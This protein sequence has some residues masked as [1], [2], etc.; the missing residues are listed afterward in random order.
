MDESNAN[1]TP[2]SF[3][4]F[5]AT[6]DLFA[7]KIVPSLYLL[8]TTGKLPNEFAVLGF[9]RQAL[10]TELFQDHVFVHLKNAAP[11][12]TKR[13]A[14]EFL[15]LFTYQQGEFADEASF[16]R[17]REA[18]EARDHALGFP[19]L[20]SFYLA[21]PP[22]LV[23]ILVPHLAM[24]APQGEARQILIEKP[25]G[26]DETSAREL[27]A[28][29][30]D[31]FDEREIFRID[32]YLAKPALDTLLYSR[33]KHERYNQLL[34]EEPIQ[35][36]TITLLETLGVEKRGAFYD[37][38]GALKDV[39]QNHL[40]EMLALALMPIPRLEPASVCQ[41]RAQFL[42]SLPRLST[43]EVEEQTIRAQ[44]EGYEHIAGVREGS[45]TETYFRVQFALKSAPY[46]DVAVVLESGK[47]MRALKKD[48]VISFDCN[49]TDSLH[50]ELEPVPRIYLK[51]GDLITTLEEFK[52]PM[53]SIQYANEYATLFASAWRGDTTHFPTAREVER[54]W[55]F[56][57]PIVLAW[58][59][60]AP[61]LLTYPQG[62]VLPWSS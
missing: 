62:A 12:V 14:E 29:L 30:H 9:G 35:A 31:F 59:E 46:R 26:H 56:I 54:L 1:E 23:R 44:Y 60:G 33:T 43:K 28:F 51:K 20:K 32:H 3:V 47:R 19:A 4:V 61:P 42:Q 34:R 36:I 18:L 40:L 21:V 41:A 13:G 58:E 38:I 6:G 37:G 39:G 10:T 24:V 17:L 11:D 16:A 45:T 48:I 5:G 15:N 7:R 27:T 2:V 55:H 52:D 49:H 57:D 8:Y 53:P 25:Y 50:I 22:E